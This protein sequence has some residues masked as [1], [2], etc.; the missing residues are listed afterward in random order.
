MVKTR[1]ITRERIAAIEPRIRPYVR[2]T[3]VMRVDMADF[4]KSPFPVDLKLEC[5]QH[6]GSFKARGAFTNLLTRPAPKAGVVAASG[7]NHGA[8]VA[9]AAMKL[10]HKA[11][12]F[13]PEVSPPAKI[14]RI[15]GYG[16]ELVVGGARYAEALAASED[17]AAR[18]GA[19]QIHAFNQEETL[20][21]QG[22]LGMEIEADLPEIDTLLVAVG[23]GGLIGGTAAWFSGR[24]RIIAIEPEGAP[25]LYRAL[26]A[27]E[28]VDAPAEG[29][30][31]DSL[32]P[33][34]VGEMMFPLAEAFVERSILVSDD[35]IVAAQ[36]ALWDRVRI[37]A[38]P[39]GA[40]AFAAVLSGRYEPAEGERVAVLVCGSN[41]NPAN[42]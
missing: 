41:T 18:T 17:F 15:R 1:T 2:H 22:T 35:D 11:S 8:A 16:A 4:G 32:A 27:G 31:A 3:P 30:A 42:F 9:Y 33:K 7:G 12:I 5:L 36:K 13:V 37:I 10:G 39:G 40:A 6:S 24:I 25:T 29:I 14:E 21:G 34:R 26:E 38:E 23:G 28:P 20:L 19:L